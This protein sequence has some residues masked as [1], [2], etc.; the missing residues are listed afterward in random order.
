MSPWSNR[1]VNSTWRGHDEIAIYLLVAVNVA[2]FTWCVQRA[3]PGGLSAAVLLQAGALNPAALSAGERWRLVAHGFLHLNLLHLGA[4]MLCLVVFGGPLIRRVRTLYFLIIY[5]AAIVAGG[6]ASIY[7]H[8][9]APFVSVGASGGVSGLLGALVGLTLLGKPAVP[10]AF[11]AVNIGLNVLLAASVANIDWASHLG[12]F[13]GG[14]FA[15]AMLDLAERLNGRLL[16]CK[17]PE[18]L[19]VNGAT[20]LTAP[21]VAVLAFGARLPGLDSADALTLGVGSAAVCLG[22]IKLAD[23]VLPLRKGLGAIIVA[24]AVG[25]AA[26]IWAV[27]AANAPSLARACWDTF[28]VSLLPYLPLLPGSVRQTYG[29]AVDLLCAR[30]DRTAIGL[31]AVGFLLTLLLHARDL[32]RSLKDV[33][34]VGATL[35]ANRLRSQGL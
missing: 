11:L 20:L 19:K 31:G 14:L 3:M 32:R 23:L 15:C 12:G 5:L 16:R 29:S 33:G 30:A 17:F 21:P 26:L 34:F 1:S 35:K 2:V 13:T 18:W 8:Q 9:D 10:A 22:L 28:Y 4:N 27:G 7:A 6:I 25:N 24:L